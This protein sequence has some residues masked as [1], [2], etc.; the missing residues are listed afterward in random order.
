MAT[1]LDVELCLVEGRLRLA[2]RRAR[3]LKLAQDDAL[4]T[5]MLHLIVGS[6]VYLLPTME[7]RMR[8]DL[9]V[10]FVARSRGPATSHRLSD[11]PIKSKRRLGSDACCSRINSCQK[12]PRQT[13]CRAVDL[14]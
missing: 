5:I 8:L 3:F 11:S 12:K 4:R 13:S 7:R 14:G 2:R 1:W 10:A 6:Y 9:P